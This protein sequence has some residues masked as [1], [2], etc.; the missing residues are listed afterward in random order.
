MDSTRA[1][2]QQRASWAAAVLVS[3][4]TPA[5]AGG[6]GAAV[7]AFDADRVAWN[8]A[9]L[10]ASKFFLSLEVDMT[11]REITGE[12]AA[13]ELEDKDDWQGLQPPAT[14]LDMR[15]VSD[16]LGRRSEV[17]MLF[18]PADG[19]MLQRTTY[20]TGNRY[21]L[22][23]YRYGSGEVLR[24]TR[25]P[26]AGEESLAPAAWSRE[27]DELHDFPADRLS[28]PVTEP[29]ALIYLAAASGLDTPGEGFELSAWAD[30]RLRTVSVL[31]LQPESIRQDYRFAD[32]GA[33]DHRKGDVEAVR[34]AIRGR[35]LDDASEAD[36]DDFELLGLTRL[37]LYLDPDTRAPLMLTG[38]LS[39]FG[40]VAFRLERLTLGPL[41]RTSGHAPR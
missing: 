15:Y 31:V 40:Q 20:D 41:D 32:A 39:R 27:G 9:R 34:V 1:H 26:N 24:E 8:E 12:A 16:G 2:A 7:P 23:R 11:L 22:R 13:T 33:D 3:L 35:P 30:D 6:D 4:L 29:A 21:R 19:A 10:K 28:G 5:H 25:R 36:D 37:E 17:Q 38:R 14:V 18:D